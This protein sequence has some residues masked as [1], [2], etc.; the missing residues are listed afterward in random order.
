MSGAGTNFFTTKKNT[1]QSQVKNY[2]EQLAAISTKLTNSEQALTLLAKPSLTQ[3]EAE[4]LVSLT[5]QS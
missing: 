4:Q 3:A 5:E 2:Q 1:Y